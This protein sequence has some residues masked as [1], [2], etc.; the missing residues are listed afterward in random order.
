MPDNLNIR[1]PDD[2][3]KINIHEPWELKYWAKKFGVSETKIVESV[4]AVG[5]SVA[6]VKRHLER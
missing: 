2:P 4:R 1:Q 3:K 6:A 5:V